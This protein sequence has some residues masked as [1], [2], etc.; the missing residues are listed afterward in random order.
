MRGRP[1][2]GP[3]L[4][5]PAL[6]GLFLFIAVPFLAAV[7]WSFTNLRMGSPLPVEFVGLEQ[8]RRVLSDPSFRRALLNNG[9]F[10]LGV[11]PLQTALA[12]GLALALNGR[13]RGRAVFRTV[14]FMPVVFPM[15]LVAV[16]WELLSSNGCL[17]VI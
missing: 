12:L 15:A 2:A 10:A 3:L 1:S 13:F 5:A 7:A 14:F 8:Y 16:V 9:L 4:A 6:L 11:V 17:T